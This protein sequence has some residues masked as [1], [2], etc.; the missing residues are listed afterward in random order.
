MN[1]YYIPLG[2]DESRLIGNFVRFMVEIQELEI[3]LW[4]RVEKCAPTRNQVTIKIITNI[5]P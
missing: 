2:L 1:T 3:L 5:S 4:I